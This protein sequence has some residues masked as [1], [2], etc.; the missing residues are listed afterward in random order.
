MILFLGNFT[1]VKELRYPWNR[2]LGG[3]QTVCARFG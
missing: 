3:S 2:R 1:P